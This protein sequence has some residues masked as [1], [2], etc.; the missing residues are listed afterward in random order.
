MAQQLLNAVLI[1]S[2]Y[3][4]FAV[5][6]SLVFGVLDVLNLA[7]SAVFMLGA[8]FAYSLVVLHGLPLWAA[9]PLAVG[10]AGAMGMVIE[11]V[12]PR[13]LG[14]RNAPPIANPIVTRASALTFLA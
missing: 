5:G 3:A 8:V 2:I 1:G 6:Y 14:R 4:L 11:F 7:H 13:Q 9:A 12:A 10:G